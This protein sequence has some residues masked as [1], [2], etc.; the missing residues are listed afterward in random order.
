MH[1]SVH[2]IHLRKIFSC[3]TKGFLYNTFR[4]V[5]TAS[6]LILVIGNPEKHHTVYTC[7][8]QVWNR[9]SP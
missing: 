8:L 3:L 9:I 1:T 7:V 4:I 2:E 6:Y 5:G